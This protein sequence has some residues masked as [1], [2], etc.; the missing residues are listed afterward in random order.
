MISKLPNV[1]TSIFTVMSSLALKHNAI[2][3]GQGYPDF[4]MSKGLMAEVNNAMKE[5]FNQY[6]HANG[7]PLLLQ[8]IAEKVEFLYGNKLDVSE[9]ITITPGGTYAIYNSVTA[10]I[11]PGDEVIVFEPCYD[12][13]I[14]N[15]ELN[16]GIP[17]RIPLSFPD[18]KI[19]WQKVHEAV[20]PRTK[21]IMINTPH[22]PSGSILS[23]EDIK[24]LH[25]L[26]ENNP[27]YIMSDEVY[28]HLVFDGLT[29]HSMLR[30][31]QLFER[32][33]IAFSFGKV[34]NCTGWKMGYCI[35]PAS[36]MKEFR[37]IHQF[38]CFSVN[39]PMQVGLARFLQNKEE[40]LNLAANMQ[41]RRDYLRN[42]M[43][44]T[45][46]KLIPSHGSYFELYSYEN[47]LNEFD[48]AEKLIIECGVVAIPVTAFYTDKLANDYKVLRFCFCKKT[49]VLKEAVE[50]LKKF[51]PFE[52][53]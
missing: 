22:N 10:I 12:S 33:F 38:N 41:E 50:R 47:E 35:A 51:L 28:E 9:N 30:Y 16:G 39:T 3:L 20:T 8:A 25:I 1:G 14:P 26:V 43:A 6:S 32:S 37:K 24:Q 11:N 31:P 49:E 2:N 23:K 18:Y 7:H 34:Y 48:M 40:Y 29:H 44:Q 46:F 19:D 36:L 27:I 15:I 13:Y 42:L 17:I 4:S 52:K 5:N 53:T 45:S 21:M